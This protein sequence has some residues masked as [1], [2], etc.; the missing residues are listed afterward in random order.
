MLK[1]D[2]HIHTV[3]SKHHFLDK[4]GLAD[5]LNSPEEMVKAAVKN[6]L[7]C[8]AITE[9]NVLFNPEEAKRLS[10]KYN[11]VVIPGVE[12]Y[13]NKK[14]IIAININEL[15]KVNN[16]KEFQ[17]E[18]HKQGGLVIAPHPYDPLGRGTLDFKNVDAI[19]V[20]NAYGPIGFKKLIETADKMGKAKVCGSDAHCT[21]H[22]GW[23]HCL[24]D[25]EPNVGSIISAIKNNKVTPVFGAVP[26]YIHMWY[27]FQKFILGK[28]IFKPALK[29]V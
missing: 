6:G 17:R 26:P 20:V 1:A 10:K 9:H 3:L 16:L 12:L 11:I 23:T 13:L 19:E 21:S 8:I 28:A 29:R 5:G 14:D 25:A 22:I 27:Y 24:I 18:V 4:I 15:P 2:F 7:D